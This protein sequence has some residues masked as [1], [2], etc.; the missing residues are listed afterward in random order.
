MGAVTA[1]RVCLQW[2]LAATGLWL[3]LGL[4][5]SGCGRGPTAAPATTSPAASTTR[6]TTAPSATRPPVTTPPTTAWKPAAPQASPDA[7]AASLVDAWA[8]GN[9]ATARAV[10]TPGAVSSLF[11]VPYPG[12]GL[13][14]SRGC[15]T[16][17]PPVKCTYGPP[18]GASPN[19]AIYE[20][21]VSRTSGG[22]YVSAVQVLS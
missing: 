5:L 11:A 8:A 2:V 10:A 3:A 4:A 15:S 21:S 22:W 1:R 12:P 20:L 14:M 6:A 18:G 13:A 19:D 17:F 16:A 9:R 7:A